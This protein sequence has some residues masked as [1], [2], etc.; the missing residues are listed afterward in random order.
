MGHLVIGSALTYVRSSPQKTT[1]PRKTQGVV[2][3]AGSAQGRTRRD[4]SF[5]SWSA[6]ST[7]HSTLSVGVLISDDY[8]SVL[9]HRKML[10]SYKPSHV[11][12][13]RTCLCRT[14][15]LQRL[16]VASR[17]RT[18]QEHVALRTEDGSPSCLVPEQRN[19][20]QHSNK[21]YRSICILSD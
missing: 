21:F 9:P 16:T 6:R 5:S 8:T 2:W 20:Q 12:L 10:Q 3:C 19:K 18:P 4:L 14:F 1:K 17:I 11:N 15:V 7:K 13:L